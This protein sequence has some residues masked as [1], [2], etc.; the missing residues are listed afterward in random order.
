MKQLFSSEIENAADRVKNKYESQTANVFSI[1]YWN[2]KMAT[3]LVSKNAGKYRIQGSSFHSLWM[4]TKIVI[5]RLKTY[6]GDDDSFFVS[7]SDVLPLKDFFDVVEK[8]FAVRRH[9][10]EIE[11]SL[12][13]HSQQFRSIQKRLLLRYKDK[14]P[15]SLNHLQ[16]LLQNTYQIIFDLGNKVIKTKESLARYCA[17]LSCATELL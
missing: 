4:L 6:F 7:F 5:K 15:P 2:G 11:N 13:D 8:H 1:Q 9:L 17:Q 14:S 3:V 12:N 10:V 16:V